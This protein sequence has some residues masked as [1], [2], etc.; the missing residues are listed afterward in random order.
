M[1]QQPVCGITKCNLI[2]MTICF[3]TVKGVIRIKVEHVFGMITYCDLIDKK[4][5][6]M[7]IFVCL[8]KPFKSKDSCHALEILFKLD[9]NHFTIIAN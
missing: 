6:T 8:E 4:V 7:I 2:E 1:L 3:H 5:S 9:G